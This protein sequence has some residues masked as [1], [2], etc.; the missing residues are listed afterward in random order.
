VHCKFILYFVL[1][2]AKREMKRRNKLNSQS[3]SYKAFNVDHSIILL[4]KMNGEKECPQL[5]AW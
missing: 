2:F 3:L 5:T 4:L 1:T